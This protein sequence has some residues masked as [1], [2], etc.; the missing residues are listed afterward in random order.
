MSSYSLI[1]QLLRALGNLDK[2]LFTS[3]IDFPVLGQLQIRNQLHSP[4]FVF[5][6]KQPTCTDIIIIITP[7]TKSTFFK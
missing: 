2:L 6:H 5:Q 3:Q 4:F 1:S 7:G